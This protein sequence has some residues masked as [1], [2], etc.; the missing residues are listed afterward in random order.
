MTLNV[1][2]ENYQIPVHVGIGSIIV[3]FHLY[4]RFFP[5]HCDASGVHGQ[6]HLPREAV[7]LFL[8]RRRRLRKGREGERGRKH[9]GD[10]GGEEA[11]EIQ[12]SL[13][14]ELPT[15][16]AGLLFVGRIILQYCNI[17]EAFCFFA[18]NKVWK[19]RVPITFSRFVPVTATSSPSRSRVST[20]SKSTRR[21][22][23]ELRG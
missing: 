19:T 5:R 2:F 1:A 9:Q 17:F 22:P 4:I 3:L 15:F 7:H 10:Q 13:S 16:S 12:I 14:G 11:E 18:N 8:L 21:T 23:H 20:S 6:G